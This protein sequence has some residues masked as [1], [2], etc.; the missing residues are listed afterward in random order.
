MNIAEGEKKEMIEIWRTKILQCLTSIIKKYTN[1][2]ICDILRKILAKSLIQ[3]PDNNIILYDRN[4]NAIKI[5]ANTW[6]HITDITNYKASE[7]WET[8][9]AYDIFIRKQLFSM[10]F[11]PNIIYP[12]FNTD[13]IALYFSI[14]LNFRYM[15]H[16]ELFV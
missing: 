2:D 10:K 3:K 11:E 14:P 1:F 9:F 5:S 4:T 16:T 8:M 12:F 15:Y 6:I 7:Y 13:F